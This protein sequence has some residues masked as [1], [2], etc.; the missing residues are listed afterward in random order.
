MILDDIV[1]H[2][3]TELAE[4]MAREPLAS[5]ERRAIAASLPRDFRG[6][7]RGPSVRLIAEIKKRSPSKGALAASVDPVVVARAYETGGAHAISVL[8]DRRYFDGT[9]DDL[10]DVRASTSLPCLRKDFTIAPY[11]VYEARAAGADAILLIVKILDLDT[12]RHLRRL[13]RELHMAALVE[14]QNE[15]E[16]EIALAA[17]ADLIGINNRD[18][19]TFAVDLTTTERLRRL[20]PSGPI[21]ASLSGVHHREDVDLLASWGVDAMLVGE[22]L[23][24]TGDPATKIR[25]LIA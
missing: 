14:V 12:V 18:L 4:A 24:R 3:R 17:D 25:E 9:L 19:T 11:Q 2:K 13:A 1:A 16:V 10:T 5:V 21:V 6:V 7:L 8:T 15:A 20:I 22:S 23:M